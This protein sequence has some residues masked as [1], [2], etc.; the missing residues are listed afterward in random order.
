MMEQTL[1]PLSVP[2]KFMRS[3]QS[4]LVSFRLGVLGMIAVADK[5][6]GIKMQLPL[7]LEFKCQFL[8]FSLLFCIYGLRVSEVAMSMNA[9]SSLIYQTAICLADCN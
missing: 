7:F 8:I 4:S 6:D 9:A 2:R 5:T 1:R 3:G